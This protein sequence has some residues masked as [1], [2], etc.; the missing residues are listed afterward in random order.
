MKIF[1]LFVALMAGGFLLIPT[2]DVHSA[3]VARFIEGKTTFNTSNIIEDPESAI[4]SIK[5]DYQDSLK[6]SGEKIYSLEKQKNRLFDRV[7]SNYAQLDI[8]RNNGNEKREGWISK[9]AVLK[10]LKDENNFIFL[11][12]KELNDDISGGLSNKDEIKTLTKSLRESDE[13][14]NLLSFEIERI[15]M[16][17]LDYKNQIINLETSTDHSSEQLKKNLESTKKAFAFETA[18]RSD[19]HKIVT[20][21]IDAAMAGRDSDLTQDGDLKLLDHK[22]EISAIEDLLDRKNREYLSTY[23]AKQHISNDELLTL[24]YEEGF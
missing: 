4:F 16:E 6:K 23:T 7:A 12:L 18:L 10:K 11:K 9:K 15:S 17:M 13:S 22:A 2:S 8:L 20:V 21:E 3:K 1:I 14:I 5:Q 19:L 24:I